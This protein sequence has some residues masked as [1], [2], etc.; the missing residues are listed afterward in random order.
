M[1]SLTDTSVCQGRRAE[2]FV[3]LR[4]YPQSNLR[5]VDP[6]QHQPSVAIDRQG[7]EPGALA[8]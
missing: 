7:A 2:D 8:Q 4:P 1:G 5:C 6:Q 3:P